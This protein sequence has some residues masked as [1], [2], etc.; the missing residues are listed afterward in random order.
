MKKVLLLACILVGSIQFVSAQ[1]ASID[2]TQMEAA[3]KAADQNEDIQV[4]ECKKSG[5]VTFVKTVTDNQGNNNFVPVTFDNKS[6]TFVESNQKPSC[7]VGE[8][9]SCSSKDAKAASCC[10]SKGEAKATADTKASCSSKDAKAASCCA[11]KGEAK[12]TAD[13]KASC[14]SKD[15][16]AAS[17]CASKGEAKATADTKASCASQADAKKGAC[18]ASKK[19]D[20]SKS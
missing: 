7:S 10:A 17:C 1:T 11:S 20:S 3:K 18:C 5:S 19:A 15:A 6:K 2:A 9:A 4:W 8:K 16:K 13:T 14:A 12:A